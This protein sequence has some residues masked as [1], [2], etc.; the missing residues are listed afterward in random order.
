MKRKIILF[1]FVQVFTNESLFA[2]DVDGNKSKIP[3]LVKISDSKYQVWEVIID[4]KKRTLNSTPQPI[5]KMG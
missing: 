2:G 3:S 1:L 4:Q 5:K